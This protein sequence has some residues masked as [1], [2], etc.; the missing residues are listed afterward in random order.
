[1]TFFFLKL[2]EIITINLSPH[3]NLQ[4]VHKSIGEDIDL[5][6][7]ALEYE[8]LLS[9]ENIHQLRSMNLNELFRTLCTS[10]YFINVVTLLARVLVSKPH[11]V[12]VERL[13]S[14][15]HLLK[16]ITFHNECFN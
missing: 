3:T 12:D 7:L 4:D 5:Q 2:L 13:I 10:P 11:S 14:A 8:E 15:S 16:T 1:L 9:I 6:E